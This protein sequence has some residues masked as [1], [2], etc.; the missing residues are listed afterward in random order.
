M[1]ETLCK[2]LALRTGDVPRCSMRLG[3]QGFSWQYY[4]GFMHI[5][6]QRVR[7]YAYTSARSERALRVLHYVL[8]LS[9]PFEI[10]GAGHLCLETD[11]TIWHL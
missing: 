1:R 6:T 8:G 3:K 7:I 2:G 5:T 11:R 4:N 9:L 10:S